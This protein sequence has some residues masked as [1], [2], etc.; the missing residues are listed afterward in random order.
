MI[1]I[2]D[3]DES[4]REATRGL[5][6]S[7]GFEANALASSEDFLN[8]NGMNDTSCLITDIQMRGLSGVELQSLLLGQGHRTPIIFISAFPE[9]RI[10]TRVLDAGAVGFLGKPFNEECLIDYLNRALEGHRSGDVGQ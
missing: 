8:S 4:V 3:D 5:V 7:L 9:E 10:R 2:I 1:A 6:R